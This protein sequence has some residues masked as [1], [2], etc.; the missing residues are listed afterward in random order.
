ML[1][2]PYFQ[3]DL[4]KKYTAILGTLLNDVVIKRTND[5]GEVTS[6][7]R[8][9]IQYSGKDAFIARLEMEP[10]LEK[11]TSITLPRISYELMTMVPD[12]SRKYASNIKL[13][14]QDSDYPSNPRTQ[15]VG[16]PFNFEYN[17][18]VYSNNLEDG[19]KIV[20]QIVPFFTWDFTVTAELIPEMGFKYDVPVIIGQPQQSDSYTE[21]FEKRRA[22]VWTIPFTLKG[23][24]FGPVRNSAIIK[25]ANVT[26]RIVQG[27]TSMQDAVGHTPASDRVTV[28]PGLTANG[29]PTTNASLSVS[30][31]QI[32][33]S[34]PY[35]YIIDVAGIILDEE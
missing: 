11:K 21:K 24:M 22:C 12:P 5:D 29:E 26:F 25:F 16:V 6:T 10:T 8:V 19:F 31:E 30:Y 32:E 33:P 15:F 35:D 18:Y 13:A 28:R 2:N 34:D 3:H 4:I 20:E 9:P 1:K 17:V 14:V 23:L 7:I 27:N